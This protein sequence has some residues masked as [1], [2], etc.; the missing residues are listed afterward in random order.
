[1]KKIAQVTITL[2]MVLFLSMG[3]T[4]RAQ[5][6][7]IQGGGDTGGPCI[8]P[9]HCRPRPPSNSYTT[10][11]ASSAASRVGTVAPNDQMADSVYFDL[12]LLFIQIRLG[13]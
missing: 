9:R 13:L 6:P 11:S 10:D 7:D 8:P 3:N 12:L 5:D 2:L 1:M 4:T